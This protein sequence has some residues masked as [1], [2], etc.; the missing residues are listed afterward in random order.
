MKSFRIIGRETEMSNKIKSFLLVLL[1]FFSFSLSAK[2]IVVWHSMDGPLGERF[3]EIVQQFNE[4]ARHVKNG[5]V[6]A[7]RYKG[8]YDQAIELG[9]KAAGT[10]LAP[11][12]LQ[13]Y[14]KGNLVMQANPTAYI[15]LNQLSSTPSCSLQKARFLPSIRDYYRSRQGEEGLPSLPFSVS[16]VVLFYNKDAFK[17]A[18]LDPENPPVTWEDFEKAAYLLKKHGA[19]N[20]LASAWL[21]GHHIEHVGSWHNQPVATEGNGLDGED[22]L[23]A[24]NTPFFRDH[25]NKLVSWHQLG[26]FNLAFGEKSEH[27]FAQQEVVM[28]TD[29]ANRLSHLQRLVKDQ[30]NIGVAAFPYWESV[31]RE[32]YNT[33]VN[34]AS[35]WA[36]KGHPAEDYAFVQLFFEFLASPEVQSEWHR[37]TCYLPVVIG[38]QALAEKQ[39]FYDQ[40]LN[41]KVAKIAIDSFMKRTP[42]EFSRGV[43]LP[44]FPVIRDV[45]VQELKAAI[46][47]QQSVEEALEHCVNKSNNII[48]EK[49]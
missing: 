13:V 42:G 32:P 44:K 47:G 33:A 7:L 43:L 19:N 31:V 45:M 12:I 30:F 48:K 29:S 2:E 4:R 16:S 39:H 24:I 34:G 17:A 11:H 22:A 27:A 15:P 40:G 18:G 1:L 8:D 21:S 46:K 26:I 14:E 9:L 41:G 20:I 28:L 36:I 23:V 3:L 10:P 6:V 25:F 38:V 49:P 5:M 37:K 35:F